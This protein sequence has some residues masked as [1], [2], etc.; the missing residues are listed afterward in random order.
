M[1]S[2]TNPLISNFVFITVF[3]SCKSID[4]LNVNQIK[5]N[6]LVN[7]A[8]DQ[9]SS[10]PE[11][12][13]LYRISK[14]WSEIKPFESVLLR[15]RRNS[16][17][18]RGRSPKALEDSSLM[19]STICS[20]TYYMSGDPSEPGSNFVDHLSSNEISINLNSKSKTQKNKIDQDAKSD[21]S[22]NVEQDSWSPSQINALEEEE[23]IIENPE[24][25][26]EEEE[27]MN[28]M[29]L[30]PFQ[31]ISGSQRR[32]SYIKEKPLN[33][34]P[35][36]NRRYGLPYHKGNEN[37]DLGNDDNP[38]HVYYRPKRLKKIITTK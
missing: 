38:N 17:K 3:V 26:E 13:D 34:Q 22:S 23:E 2:I 35:Y 33:I 7:I 21:P 36:F 15:V 31:Q 27:T 37:V 6:N 8:K 18:K 12:F 20:E 5:N 24:D 9:S 11:S 30:K 28:K 14:S 10:K 16:M 1:K 19:S 25:G 4:I 32:K 29:G